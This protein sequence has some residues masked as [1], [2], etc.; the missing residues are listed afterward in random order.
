MV[1]G[2]IW[3]DE[4]REGRDCKSHCLLTVLGRRVVGQI[5]DRQFHVGRVIDLFTSGAS[6]LYVHVFFRW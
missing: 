1:K 4:S 6:V 2:T 5:D 3:R